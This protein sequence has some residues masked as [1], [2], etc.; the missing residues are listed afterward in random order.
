[1][2]DSLTYCVLP[3][4]IDILDGVKKRPFVGVCPLVKEEP[5]SGIDYRR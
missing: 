1:M 4:P 3:N 5:V 2:T